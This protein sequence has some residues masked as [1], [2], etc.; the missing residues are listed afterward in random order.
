MTWR[1]GVEGKHRGCVILPDV[2]IFIVKIRSVAETNHLD[3]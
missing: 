2:T 3:G 1:G